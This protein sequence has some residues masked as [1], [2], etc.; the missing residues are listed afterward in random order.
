LVSCESGA[1]RHTE[2]TAADELHIEAI[3]CID[4]P[5]GLERAGGLSGLSRLFRGLPLAGQLPQKGR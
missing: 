2:F 5:G 4:T 1:L 3:A